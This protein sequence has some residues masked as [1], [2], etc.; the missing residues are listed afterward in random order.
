MSLEW[1]DDALCAEVGTEIFFPDRGGNPAR[2]LDVCRRCEVRRECL[3][4]VMEL[5]AGTPHGVMGIWGGT[6]GTQ[7]AKMKSARRRAS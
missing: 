5:E 4:Y 2:A 3:D 7:R 6:T 1:M